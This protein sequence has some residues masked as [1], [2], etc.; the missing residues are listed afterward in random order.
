MRASAV[1]SILMIVG[2]ALGTGVVALLGAYLVLPAIAPS[3]GSNAESGGAAVP[4]DS[5]VDQV[6]ETD[7]SD[8]S[9]A[10]TTAPPSPAEAGASGSQETSPSGA[11]EAGQDRE[12][13]KAAA[14][15][16]GRGA[17]RPAVAQALRDSL[18]T[19]RRRL[20]R[21]REEADTLREETK[22]LR[23]KLA[24][25]ETERAKVNEL[26]DALLDM[27]RRG[28]TNLLQDVDMSVLRKLYQQTS[29][30]ARTRL[31]QSMEPARGAQFVNRVVEGETADST[32][33]S[34]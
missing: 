26:S 6:S 14:D 19:L 4:P 12:E 10:L 22:M 24:A 29:G 25:A 34:E 20:R 2:A 31:L 28:L 7:S 13:P 21:T 17:T 15:T 11:K 1:T 30:R 3:V 9:P 32:A 23:E 5:T 8:A 18:A 16:A 27:R 33:A